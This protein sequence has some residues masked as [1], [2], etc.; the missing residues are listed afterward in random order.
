MTQHIANQTPQR[1][2]AID[3]IKELQ[4]SENDPALAFVE[5]VQ[6]EAVLLSPAGENTIACESAA[7]ADLG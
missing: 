1:Q 3:E 6:I 4:S 2:Y 7:I 5:S